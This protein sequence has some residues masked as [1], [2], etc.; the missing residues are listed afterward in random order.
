MENLSG[1]HYILLSQS[2]PDKNISVSL[3]L[4]A[5]IPAA[6]V[7]VGGVLTTGQERLTVKNTHSIF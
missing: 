7:A 4:H 2:F 6:T 5:F 3:H 1:F